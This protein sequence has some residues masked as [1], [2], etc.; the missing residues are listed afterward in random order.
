M[1]VMASL[2]YYR[3]QE[4]LML[5][6]KAGSAT[7]VIEAGSGICDIMPGCG[8]AFAAALKDTSAARRRAERELEY[9]IRK[10]IKILGCNDEAYPRRLAECA[11]APIAVFY[12][13]TANLNS[14]RVINVV[15]TRRCTACGRD[16]VIRLMKAV[17]ETCPDML[18]VSGL[19]YGV[20][21]C[22]HREALDNRLCTVAV[23]AHGLD[24]LYPSAHRETAGR[25]TEHGGLLTEYFTRTN[26][27][28]LNFLNRNRIVAGMSDATIVVE[29]ASHGGALVTARLA[30]EYGRAVFA[31]PGRA[32]DICSEGCNNL[33][34]DGKARLITSAADLMQAMGWQRETPHG[35]IRRA[36]IEPELFPEYTADEQLIVNELEK[37]GDMHVNLIAAATALPMGRLSA[38]L[39][40]LEMK[41]ALRCL[42][43]GVYHKN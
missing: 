36:G 39:F 43:G 34:R 20:D 5:Y 30:G 6:R 22:A 15:G 16:N 32:S 17:E 23:L 40:S 41:G 14:L 38:S 1:L 18:V 2:S 31:F 13:G 10:D 19:A 21:I 28:K 37:S 4:A 42:A 26:A 8:K 3:R 7:A 11:D 9:C 33:I 29:S 35:R 12:K 27:D 25:M 24:N